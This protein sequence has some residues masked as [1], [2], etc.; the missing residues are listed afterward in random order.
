MKMAGRIGSKMQP[1]GE[2]GMA[3]KRKPDRIKAK[4]TRVPRDSG[5]DL[6]DHGD[7]GSSGLT[8]EQ[9]EAISEELKDNDMVQPDLLERAWKAV[10]DLEETDP[11]RPKT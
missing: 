6:A 4:M 10:R 8:P 2:K 5:V 11:L 1:K 9:M 3:R 7:I